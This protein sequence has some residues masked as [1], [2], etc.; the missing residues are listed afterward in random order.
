MTP[1]EV[2]PSTGEPAP[3]VPGDSPATPVLI[4]HVDEAGSAFTAN[5][6]A[7]DRPFPRSW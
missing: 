5:F 6:R 1:T 4:A 3:T 7:E 2:S